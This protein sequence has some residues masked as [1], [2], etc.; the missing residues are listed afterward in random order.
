MARDE[1]EALNLGRCTILIKKRAEEYTEGEFKRQLVSGNP[2]LTIKQ[3]I[4]RDKQ[5]PEKD[6]RHLV[7]VFSL[8]SEAIE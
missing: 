8:D 5:T 6:P 4:L 7:V 2:G 3:L 1:D